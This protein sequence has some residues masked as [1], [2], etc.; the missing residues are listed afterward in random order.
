MNCPLFLFFKVAF[1][2]QEVSGGCSLPSAVI[3]VQELSI[4][5]F[6]QPL[7]SMAG[8]MVV[9]NSVVLRR[10]IDRYFHQFPVFV[11]IGQFSRAVENGNRTIPIVMDHYPHPDV[12]TTI[13][14][15]RDLQ[16][17]PVNAD[18]IVGTDGSFLLLAED[19]IKILPNPRNER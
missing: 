10:L 5:I 19:I 8:N 17:M 2:E 9:G 4:A 3:L 13:F 18:T 15:R 1:F 14:V 7:R 11:I 6:P 12:M 16:F